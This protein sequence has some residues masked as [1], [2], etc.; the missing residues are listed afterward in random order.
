LNGNSKSAVWLAFALGAAVYVAYTLR[1][2]LL[3]LWVS[4]L[5]AVLFTP[6]VDWTS[7]WSIRGHHLGRGASLL[8]LI[9]CV[10]IALGLFFWL[11]LPP[12]ARD[13]RSLSQQMPEYVQRF[14]NWEHQHLPAT[15]HLDVEDIK[16]YGEP[17]VGGIGGVFRNV[18]NGV[19][20]FITVILLAAYFILDGKT[21]F[22][23]IISLF[24]A[25][26][27][28]RLRATLERGGSRMR[29]WLAGQGLLMLIHGV[30]AT[31][32]FWLLGVRYFYVLGV[33]A[34]IFN[35]IPVLGPVLTLISAGLVAA[36]DSFGK[37]LGVTAFYL[38][39]H[40][41]ES[42]FL[43]PRI[44][45]ARVHLP[46]VA[47]IIA[48]VIGEAVA[49]ILGVLIAVP[50]AALISEIISEYLIKGNA[51]AAPETAPQVELASQ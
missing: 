11:A 26:Q 10:L 50:T 14:V 48:I 37:V 38:I 28:E 46:A 51:G 45:K 9:A 5:M 7:R 29:R 13:A 27:Q 35:I 39:Y 22:A 30:A 6:V 43:N 24:P 40:N 12:I 32:A 44:M 25:N 42:I 4:V 23:W 21:S 34:A 16:R 18:T 15:A 19:V 20:K 17:L 3:L 47:I 8:I 33:L 2:T 49:G 31:L 36:L 41:L 1:G